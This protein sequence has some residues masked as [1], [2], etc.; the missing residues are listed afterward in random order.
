M[1]VYFSTALTLAAV[2]RL[3][4]PLNLARTRYATAGLRPRAQTCFHV[5]RSTAKKSPVLLMTKRLRI[6]GPVR[7]NLSESADSRV[8]SP[9]SSGCHIRWSL[10]PCH[11]E[12]PLCALECCRREL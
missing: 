8:L 1:L 7:M 9:P 10:H 2:V 3:S 5:R 12:E 6:S 4:P 11:C